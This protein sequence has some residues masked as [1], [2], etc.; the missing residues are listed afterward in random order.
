MK[1][2]F[3]LVELL[4]VIVVLAIIALIAIPQI[5]NVISKARK[6]AA[7]NS[8]YGYVE[9]IE[10]QVILN[11]MKTSN[12]K[13]DDGTYY[14]EDLTISIK[15]KGPDEG[16]VT[17]EKGSV[18]S[19]KLCI[20]K[21][22]IDYDG[23]EASISS[24]NYCSPTYTVILNVGGNKQSKELKKVSSTTFEVEITDMTNM[25]CNNGAI[26]SIENNTLT[27]SN[28]YGDTTCQLNSSIKDTIDNLDNTK[29]NIVMLND[30]EISD[31]LTIASGKTVN[32]DL[33]GKTIEKITNGV[34]LI[35]YGWLVLNDSKGA[36]IVLNSGEACGHGIVNLSY[37][38]IN[39]GTLKTTGT[40]SPLYIGSSY[41]F[42]GRAVINDSKIISVN[43]AGIRIY[44]NEKNAL[45]I[46]NIYMNTTGGTSFSLS[47]GNMSTI[48]INGGYFINNDSNVI[49]NNRETIFYINQTDKPIYMV[50]Y[51]KTW[52]PVIR[53]TSVG[54]VNINAN[55]A[56][57]CTS[58]S[59]D[60]TSGLCVYAEGN[61]SI[62]SNEGN[63]A[64]Q[65]SSVGNSI[66]INGGTYYGGYQGITTR[67]GGII[68]VKNAIVISKKSVLTNDD[69]GTLNI[70]NLKIYLFNTLS[71][72]DIY[73]LNNKQTGT[74]NYD[75]STIFT[76]G[77]N[78]PDNSMIYNPSGTINSNY[79]G[80]CTE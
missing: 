13:I 30:E 41:S 65:D 76:N 42:Q 14:V 54:I 78:I 39:G 24:N 68:N 45:T 69:T 46:N 17:I 2:G 73:D 31:T 60:T 80:T 22:S 74:I 36:G 48:N 57:N 6:N 23:N 59:E 16:V 32:L 18:K 20:G 64:V 38:E 55:Q 75:S 21:Y 44:S 12:S 53:T 67:N 40:C 4:A 34:L 26:P 52:K 43:A 19:A 56:D 10:N 33:N 79:T 29:T 77:T 35:N 9:A 8:A 58:N 27:I 61:G 5:T 25:S 70:C 28:I 7:I 11:S 62:T 49:Y 71:N 51:A 50:S 63:G 47:E 37:I 66:N 1:K 3:T 72:V 15:G